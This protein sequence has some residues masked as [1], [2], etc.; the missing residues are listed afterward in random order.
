[1]AEAA[2]DAKPPETENVAQEH[3]EKTLQEAKEATEQAVKATQEA[4]DQAREAAE[5]KA[6]EVKEA[7]EAA[8]KATQ[9]AVDQAR[10]A[11]EKKAEE[12]QKAVQEAMDASNKAVEEAK[13]QAEEAAARAKEAADKALEATKQALEESTAQAKEQYDKAAAAAVEAANAAHEAADKAANQAKEAAEAAAAAAR[14][15][16]EAASGAAKEQY[17]AAAAKALEAAEAANAVAEEAQKQANEAAK[18]AVE[19]Y[20]KASTKLAE[21]SAPAVRAVTELIE[22]TSK[23]MK[24]AQ[25]AMKEAHEAASARVEELSAPAIQAIKEAHEATEARAREV[26]AAT[27]EHF[28]NATRPA[29]EAAEAAAQATKDAADA[30]AQSVTETAAEVQKQAKDWTEFYVPD[31]QF[32][33]GPAAERALRGSRQCL[34]F[35]HTLF[36]V[37]F[38]GSIINFGL[39]WF[40][41]SH[42]V[43]YFS[44]L[45][46]PSVAVCP[47]KKGGEI[48]PNPQASYDL[49]ATKFS[50][51]GD[52]RVP[53]TGRRCKMEG[54]V[55]MCL[56]MH[57][58][59]LADSFENHI[60]STGVKSKKSQSYREHIVVHTTLIDPNSKNLK[61]GFYNSEDKRPTWT[62]VP[63]YYTSIGSVRMDSVRLSG[64][65]WNFFTG[66]QKDWRHHFTFTGSSVDTSAERDEDMVPFTRIGYEFDSFYVLQANTARVSES[67]YG[68]ILIVLL[69]FAFF[70]T[71][72]I[73]EGFFPVFEK[74]TGQRV[75][76]KP[77]LWWFK[78][79]MR[80]DLGAEIDAEAGQGYGSTNSQPRRR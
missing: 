69:G 67:L 52:T 48:A 63:T 57:K 17:E 73:W 22:P 26:A 78:N 39:S 53:K 30:A 71:Y 1:M 31:G 32:G 74:R 80:N 37:L 13:Q 10:E 35:L 15:A 75:V 12:V 8:A 51:D 64:A 4:V 79:I 54:S 41:V 27:Q 25:E 46:A 2:A 65:L 34:W 68:L 47:F 3:V 20:E 58:V 9:E 60:G 38:V 29:R 5:Q 56:D 55:C 61:V 6:K 66:N 7:A 28:D 44:T 77:M 45:E 72:Y 62:T 19:V 40:E 36:G 49:Y 24:E 42:N 21:A 18:Q 33:K 59:F 23:A 70:N 50:L 76:S 43:A 11:A 14:E 16:A